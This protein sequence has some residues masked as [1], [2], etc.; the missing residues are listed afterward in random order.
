[1]AT[2]FQDKKGVLM[3]VMQQEITITSQVHCKTLKELR[4][5]DNS[6]RKV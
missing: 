2:V 3:E 6:E 1:M 4:R 5:A